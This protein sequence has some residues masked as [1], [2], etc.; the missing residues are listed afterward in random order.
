M[1]RYYGVGEYPTY[2]QENT[3]ITDGADIM[4]AIQTI[5]GKSAVEAIEIHSSERIKVEINGCVMSTRKCGEDYVLIVGR[6][7]LLPGMSYLNGRQDGG[8]GITSVKLYGTG[9]FYCQF[10][11]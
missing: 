2:P 1:N 7:V 11:Y 3:A 10:Y 5:T 6:P 4:E 9:T 8:V